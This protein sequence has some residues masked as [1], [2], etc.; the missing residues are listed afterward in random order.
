MAAAV[1]VAVAAGEDFPTSV[2]WTWKRQRGKDWEP[3]VGSRCAVA[4]AVAVAAAALIKT[5][6]L[7]CPIF[8]CV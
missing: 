3:V 4:A 6:C 5:M 8:L 7:C 1:A 2:L